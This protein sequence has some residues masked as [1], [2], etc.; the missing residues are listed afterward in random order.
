MHAGYRSVAPQQLNA[1]PKIFMPP[2]QFFPDD[3]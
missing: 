2:D 1:Y 3:T